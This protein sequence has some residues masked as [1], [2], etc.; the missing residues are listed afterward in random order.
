MINWKRRIWIFVA[1]VCV[2]NP[3]AVAASARA[4]KMMIAAANPHAA[5]AGLEILKRGGS[6]ADAAIAAQMVLNVVEPQSSGIGG[7][8]F[9]L[10]WHAADES[11]HT[12]DGRETAPAA[13]DENLFAP[14]GEKM[15]WRDAVVGGRAVGAPGLL[16]MLETAHRKHGRLPWAEL[17]APAIQIAENGFAVSPRLSESIANES[18]K[19][20]LGRYAAARKYFFTAEGKPLPPGTILKNPELADTFRKI[21]AGGARAF[22]EGEIARAIVAAVRGAADNPGA[23]SESD[24]Q[25]YRA[26]TRPPVCLPY[27]KYKVCGMGP[28]TSGGLTVL[29]I[30]KILENFDLSEIPPMSAAAAH[31]FSQAA[32]LAYADRAMH[33]ADSDFHPVPVARLLD[34]E[35]LKSRARL[36][37]PARDMGKAAPGFANDSAAG[38]SP[39]QPSTTHLSVADKYGNVLSMTSSIE[40]AFGSTLM[41]RGFLLNNQLTD[42]S[43]AAAGEDGEKIA[44]RVQANKRPRS[45]MSPMIVF[46]ED[47]APLLA[48]GS[49]GGSRIINYVA[50][51]LI[52]VLDWNLDAQGAASLPHYVN[53]NGAT[54]LEKG[55]AAEKLRG[56]LEKMGHKINIRP[57]VSGLHLIHF[58][59]GELHG[60]ADLRREGVAI[61]I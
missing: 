45:S 24:L 52:A 57:L 13:A 3:S 10:Y 42:F 22:Y 47:G 54:D 60:G 9:M 1:A 5:A 20:G 46:D 33:I 30:L 58:T 31:L 28:P 4:E 27:R 6:A 8:A 32:R 29:Q 53:R 59:D 55:T 18:E 61:G 16:A 23:L 25:N 15:K 40:N 2:A 39:A 34:S 19:G 48:A 38:V 51:S 37:S 26:K 17:F 56:D 21:A 44:N 36:I 50:R 43:F 41:A 12:F 49:P 7:G 11:L 35:Y 14:G